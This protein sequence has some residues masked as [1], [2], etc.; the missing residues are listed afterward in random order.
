MRQCMVVDDSAV[1][2]KVSRALFESMDFDV[3]EAE[4]GQ[5]ALDLCR[6][7]LPDL[8]LLDWHMPVMG[9]LDFLAAMRAIPSSKRPFVLYCTTEPDTGDISRA[10]YYVRTRSGRWLWIYHD[11]KRRRWFLQGEVQ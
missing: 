9:A 10:Y 8:I 5:Q 1:I 6:G 7:A 11:D 4:N 3:S 2:R